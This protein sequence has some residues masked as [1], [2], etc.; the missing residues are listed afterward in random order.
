MTAK[1]TVSLLALILA[2]SVAVVIALS[3]PGDQGSE[4]VTL[5]GCLRTGSDPV[6]YILR[7][8]AVPAD[9]L[10][11]S[12]AAPPPAAEDYLLVQIPETVDPGTMVNH[13]VE[14]AGLVSD[15]KSGPAP[16]REANA[17]ERALKRLTVQR[18]RD[19]APN[20]SGD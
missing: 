6:V 1:R 2:A 5:T 4:T 10:V 13:R 20:C 14:I 19:V 8:A 15:A 17:A 12:G 11:P 16:P 3:S 7:G 18:A 9:A